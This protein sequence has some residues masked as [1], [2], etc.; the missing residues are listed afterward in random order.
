MKSALLK[1]MMEVTTEICA[2]LQKLDAQKGQFGSL[3]Q[4]CTAEFLAGEM[5]RLEAEIKTKDVKEWSGYGFVQTGLKVSIYFLTICIV[6]QFVV[7]LPGKNTRSRRN[8]LNK[9]LG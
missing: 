2:L 1:E 8:Y 9:Q 4:R 6:V 7:Q 3:M 5:V